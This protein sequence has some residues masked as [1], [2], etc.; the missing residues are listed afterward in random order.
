MTHCGGRFRPPDAS[1][2]LCRVTCC[3]PFYSIG[4][5]R[6][7]LME[8]TMGA[9]FSPLPQQTLYSPQGCLPWVLRWASHR[10]EYGGGRWENTPHC[11]NPG[12]WSSPNVAPTRSK[13]ALLGP[14]GND[15]LACFALFVMQAFKPGWN[16][17]RKWVPS[18]QGVL[19]DSRLQL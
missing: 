15:I 10:R 9:S 11:L 2:G 18:L 13:T 16:V 3:S 17:L 14:G 4:E 5:I 12:G 8:L 6:V 7:G 19:L 1:L